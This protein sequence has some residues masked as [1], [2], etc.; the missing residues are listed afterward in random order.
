MKESICERRVIFKGRVQGV[1]FRAWVYEQAR[2]IDLK[3]SIRNLPDGTVEMQVRGLKPQ[4]EAFIQ[5]I[6]EKGPGRIEEVVVTD[7]SL[8]TSSE[9]NGFQHI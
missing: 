5:L 4:L 2:R 7:I 8:K 3:G 1:G 9:E 6:K